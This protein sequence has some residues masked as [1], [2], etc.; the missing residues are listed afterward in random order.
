MQDMTDQIVA[1]LEDEFPDWQ[2]WTSQRF[3]GG[4]TWYARRRDDDGPVLEARSADELA[5]EIEQEEEQ[6][7]G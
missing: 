5:D 1:Q 3:F 2:V 4:T 6:E 7:E